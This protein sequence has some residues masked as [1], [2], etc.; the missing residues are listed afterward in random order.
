M[1]HAEALT[2]IE[3]IRKTDYKLN[4][5]ELGLVRSLEAHHKVS[6]KQAEWLLKIYAKSTGGGPFQKRSYI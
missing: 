2:V 3:Y 6:H 1:T 5:L 4:D